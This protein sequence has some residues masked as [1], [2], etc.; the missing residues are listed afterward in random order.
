MQYRSVYITARDETEAKMISQILVEE[1]LA[2]CV[3]YFPI[4]SIY[5]WK[6]EVQKS[7]EVALIAKTRA[8]L[9]NKVI[10]RVKKLHSYQVPCIVSWIIEDGNQ[11]YLEWIKE[12][13]QEEKLR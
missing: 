7:N 12:S 10:T 9:V 11:D 3:N 4:N 6:G 2:A 8:A 5:R 13:T 1:K